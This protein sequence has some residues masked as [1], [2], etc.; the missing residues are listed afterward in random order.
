[1][2]DPSYVKDMHNAASR[3]LEYVSDLTEDRF[4]EDD[5]RIDAV[6]RQLEI[7]GEA[8]RRVSDE[9]QNSHPD[10]PWRKIIGLRNEL[11]HEYDTVDVELLWIIIMRD[12]PDLI[13][14]LE[15]LN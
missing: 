2:R 1:M 7:L 11:I 9:F 14:R 10:I 15:K 13:I 3:V 12:L 4:L 5:I 8:A 6:I